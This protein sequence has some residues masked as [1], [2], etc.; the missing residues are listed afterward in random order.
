MDLAEKRKRF[1]TLHARPFVVPNPWDPGS[2]RLLA[3]EGFAALATTSAGM[4]N[5]NFGR[6]DGDVTRDEVLAHARAIVGATS[7]PVSADFEN[8]FG[9]NATEVSES[10]RLA[11]ETGLAGLSVEDY[12][13]PERGLYPIEEATERVAAAADAARADAEPL[14]VTA[15]AENFFRGNPDLGD[16]IVRL[17]AFQDAGADVLYAPALPD[18][19]ALRTV[20]AETD[21]PVNTLIMPGGPSVSEIFEAG[22]MRIT[23]GSA[24]AMTAQDALIQAARELRDEGTHGF[25]LQAVRSAGD[26]AKALAGD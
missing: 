13:G 4:A 15:R 8:G 10:V 26:V 12:G 20:V 7:L 2:A 6:P 24:L 18:L 14:V 19:D 25:W 21:R 5:A 3:A 9:A 23:T 17:Q 22:A 11:S 1:R 16:A